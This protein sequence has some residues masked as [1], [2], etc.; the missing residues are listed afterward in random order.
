MKLPGNWHR[1]LWRR[2]PAA[3]PSGDVNFEAAASLR[4]RRFTGALESLERSVD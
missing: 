3:A 4:T 2:K 1:R